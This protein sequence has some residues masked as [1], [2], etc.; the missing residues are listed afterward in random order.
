M[1]DETRALTEPTFAD[2]TTLRVGGSIDTYIEAT[3]EDELVEAVRAADDAD[4]PLL[5]MGS[6][7]NMLV[8]DEGFGGVVVRDVRTGIHL[9]SADAC[10]GANIVVPAGHT[11]DD[12]VVAAIAHGWVGVEA[13][14]GIPGTVGAAPVQN[15]G[16]YGQEV[17]GVVASVRVW[18]RGES[19]TRT[20]SLVE[21]GFGY[22][23]SMLKQ[24]TQ[25]HEVGP[26]ETR[27]P[28]AP[29]YPTPRYVVLEVTFQFRLGTLSAPIG[30]PELARRLGVEVGARVES[31][32]VREAVLELRGAK[33]MLLD[34]PAAPDHDRWSAGSFFTNPVIPAELAGELPA[35][36]PRYPV[37]SALPESTTG[38]SLGAVDE[39]L[40]KTSAAWLIER[41][42]FSKGYG[43]DGPGSPATV[44][45]RHT[46]A[47]TNRGSATAMDI[48]RLA[49]EIRDGVVHTFGIELVPEPVLVGGML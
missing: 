23:T 37:R 30:Y 33:G 29:W 5:V 11:M 43:I 46:L 6:G 42:G 20:L 49:R 3:S 35:G 8:A 44:S 45:T 1:T 40:V 15:I 36:A 28:R 9:D 21:L 27:D 7:S 24:S 22:R 25:V 26:G 16:A 38:P 12:V 10:G 19:R 13:L 4:R 14:S 41:A 18:D 31:A 48:V 47:L 17:S 34:D 2:L 39:S 32:A